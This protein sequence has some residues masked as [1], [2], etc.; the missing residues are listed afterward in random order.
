MFLVNLTMGNHMHLHYDMWVTL[1]A[2][3]RK[4]VE[5]KERLGSKCTVSLDVLYVDTF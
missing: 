1:T 5:L 4:P 3:F 2:L